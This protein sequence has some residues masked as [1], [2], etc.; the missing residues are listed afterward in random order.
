MKRTTIRLV[1]SLALMLV[2]TPL[3]AAE[4]SETELA[5]ASQNPVANMISIPIQSNFN[6]NYGADRDKSQIV[7]N[8]QPVIP[9]SLNKDWNLITRTINPHHL[10]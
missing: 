6:F 5:K 9:I 3:W 2:S 8:V 10:Y 1:L 4:E 7:T